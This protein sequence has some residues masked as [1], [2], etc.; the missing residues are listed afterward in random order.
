MGVM[1]ISQMRHSMQKTAQNCLRYDNQKV[2]AVKCITNN[3][4]QYDA[5]DLQ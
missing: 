2:D 4:W 5:C 1:L 3:G